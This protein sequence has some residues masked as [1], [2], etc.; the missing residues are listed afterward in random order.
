MSF[1]YGVFFCSPL[2]N[3][4]DRDGDPFDNPQLAYHHAMEKANIMVNTSVNRLKIGKIERDD[5]KDIIRIHFNFFNEKPTNTYI[6]IRPIARQ[7]LS[8]SSSLNEQFAGVT[9]NE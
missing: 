9:L 2:I 5:E 3:H 8:K 7:H 6:E 4:N 1:R